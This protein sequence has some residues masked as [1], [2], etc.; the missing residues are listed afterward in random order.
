MPEAPR[1]ETK[2]GTSG[3]STN[4]RNEARAYIYPVVYEIFSK[5]FDVPLPRNGVPFFKTNCSVC[6]AKGKDAVTMI[7]GWTSCPQGWH[8]EYKGYLM[9]PKEKIYRA[10]YICVDHKPELVASEGK[11]IKTGRLNFVDTSCDALNCWKYK[12]DLEL[13][14]IVCSL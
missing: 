7:P 5:I 13:P 14:C 8:V 10:E 3:A 1:Y 2:S 9:A 4:G 6:N 11:N 12:K